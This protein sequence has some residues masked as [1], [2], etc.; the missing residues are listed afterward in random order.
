MEVEPEAVA[1]RWRLT[2][3]DR[4]NRDVVIVTRSRV[5]EVR[6]QLLIAV[7]HGPLIRG[8]PDLGRF[9]V[10]GLVGTTWR[11]AKGIMNQ[12]VSGP[13]VI[14]YP[15][16]GEITDRHIQWRARGQIRQHLIRSGADG[17]P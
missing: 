7:R 16:G 14:R 11:P 12:I 15:F 3:M 9:S 6:E 8:M 10:R 17:D 4:I 1:Q 13:G 2:A 5:T